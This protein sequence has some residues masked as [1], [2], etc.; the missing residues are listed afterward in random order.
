LASLVLGTA[1]LSASVLPDGFQEDAV[2]SGRTEPTAVRFASN[3]QVFVAEKSGLVWAYDAL[4]DTTPSLVVDLRVAVYN[5]WDRGLLGLAIAPD[6][7]ADP[8]IYVMYAHD[9]YDDG[10]GPR[11]GSSVP[12]SSTA[13][14]C[15]NPP[16]ST[17]DGCV[18][19]GRLSRIAINTATMVGTESVL[20][21]QRW[22]QQYPSHSLGDLVFGE[23][24]YLYAS[25]GD[26]ASFTFADWGQDGNPINP[27]DDPPDGIGGPQNGADAEGGA[28]RSQDILTPA[29]DTALNGAILRIDVSAE[30][31]QAAPGNPLLGNAVADDDLIIAV[32]LRNPFRF[33]ARSG[34]SEIWIG[35]VGWNVWEEINVI[36]DPGGAVE[37]FGW[38]CYE[39]GNGS[40]LQMASYAGRTLC[41]NLYNNNIPA[42]II[43]K[44][45]FYAYQHSEKVVPNELCGT[46]G[47]SVTG[48]AFNSGTNFP[49]A[50]DGALFFADSSR[51]CIWTIFADANGNPD[52]TNRQPLVS[53]AA[54]RVVDLQMGP[55]DNLYYV[56]FDGGRVFRVRYFS[57]N[58]PPQ[59][60]IGATPTSGAAPLSVQFDAS[61]SN[62]AE[63]G[64]NL[65][66]DWDLDAD[67]QFDDATGAMPV[68]TYTQAGTHLA[69]VEVTDSEGASDTAAI[70]ITADNT[71][72]VISITA[73]PSG[74][75]WS[76][77]DQIAFA[78]EA[79]D[80]QQGLLP[81][82]QLRWD[83]ILHHCYAQ[84]D[85]HTHPIT[86]FA[87]VASGFFD[88]PDHAYPSFLELRLTATDTFPADWLDSA[89][90]RR[91]KLSIDNT[92]Q[93][94]TLTGFPVL[95]ALDGSRIDYDAAATDGRDLRFTAADGTLLP[96]EI[97][98]WNP[99]GVSSV[100]VRVPQITAGSSTDHIYMYYASPA[101]ADTQDPHAV[102]QDYAGVWHLNGDSA[103]ATANGNLGTDSGTAPVAGQI[104]A[105]K[106]F[107]GSAFVSVP[108][109]ASLRITGPL[110]LEAWVQIA[111]P[112]QTGGLRVLS[113]K[114]SA[115]AAVGYNLFYQ[116]AADN[117]VSR[118]SGSDFLAAGG[119]NLN[120][121][122]H[123]LGAVHGGAGTG[124]LY[125]DGAD[126]TTDQTTSGL[127]ADGT[128]LRIG[129]E[130]GGTGA[131]NGAIDEVRVANVARS[132]SWMRA[133]YLS[134]VDAFL[135]YGP[136][137][138]FGGLT[139]SAALFLA[140][141][142]S[143]ITLRSE[144]AGLTLTLNAI[145]G[146]AP[147]SSTVI[148]GSNNQVEALSPQT[149]DGIPYQFFDW[150]DGGAQTHA[151]SAPP[152]ALT[153]TATYV[154]TAQ[155]ADSDGV[156]DS[157]DN[158]RL[159][160]NGPLA[161]DAGGASQHDADNDGYGNLCDADLNNSGLT[162]SAD[163]FILRSAL[164]T[165][166]P[167]ADLNHSG[168]VTS[169]DYFILRARL[170][171]PP[172][173]SGLHPSCPPACP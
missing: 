3:G 29:D 107:D 90:A 32:G 116:P 26:G 115:T 8:S 136:E 111:D 101:A 156:A 67:G 164:N 41:Q 34:T 91:R 88:A 113:K 127:V 44:P 57:G 64:S 37:D 146:A 137:E 135:V 104:G 154:A 76:V 171:T 78:G 92:G 145:T 138:Y 61:A 23:D 140:P 134:M 72:P 144:P 84:D 105:A 18:V 6:Y 19:Y 77:D 22:C 56:D 81:A 150:S 20:V 106:L 121:A 68:W 94:E 152:T 148:S 47:S 52:K 168:L 45:P 54:G 7:P 122:W 162:T 75:T 85:C 147:F 165:G 49:Q 12:A 141:R 97:E 25:S 169:A 33:T 73:P 123:L 36:G 125:V 160:A 166:E 99:D 55:D 74:T 66:F 151:L 131:F 59:A 69:R 159:V 96:H 17:A 124:R 120:S 170:N 15:P 4:T 157:N 143:D 28:L 80:D 71:P 173:P 63:D 21:Q 161:P 128:G 40:N 13:D 30:A 87:G 31:I 98:T 5:N 139:A 51:M 24:G 53:N 102:W 1:P 132:A 16:G 117:V 172:G 27:C 42:G 11:W 109:S 108:S 9:A 93:G 35:D 14:P 142:T 95:V 2:I 46:G 118:A 158:C 82:A 126:R 89:W 155:D 119:V 86:S 50:Y 79:D 110:T 114:P 60:A 153:L 100:W 133:Q 70:L 10:T 149:L 103:D 58:Q 130:A 39:G 62:D 83:V 38:P 65:D 112:D 129:Q 48:I 167:V 163:Y 43:A